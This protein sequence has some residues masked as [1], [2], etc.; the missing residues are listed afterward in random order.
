MNKRII[1]AVAYFG[2]F[3]APS[4]FPKKPPFS[5]GRFG[6]TADVTENLV[7]VLLLLHWGISYIMEEGGGG[8]EVWPQT[9]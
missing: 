7:G 6:K 4:G 5:V 9:W 3:T 2:N 1:Y 8:E